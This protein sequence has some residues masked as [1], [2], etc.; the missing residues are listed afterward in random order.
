MQSRNRYRSVL[1]SVCAF[2]SFS[3]IW[4]VTAFGE[5]PAKTEP[6]LETRDLKDNHGLARIGCTDCYRSEKSNLSS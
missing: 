4:S 6:I 3:V 2:L 5:E 1:F